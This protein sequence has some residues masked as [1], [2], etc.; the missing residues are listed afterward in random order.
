[1]Q[2][3]DMADKRIVL[4]D[5]EEIPGLVSIE[6]IPFEE[7][8]IDVPEI[9]NIRKIKNGVTTI[10]LLNMIYKIGRD[11]ITKSFFRDWKEKNEVKEV[12]IVKVDASGQ[13]FERTLYTGCECSKVTDPAYD[14][15]A[16]TYAQTSVT[17]V[18][19]DVINI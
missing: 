12:T 18:P 10:P 16:P 4:I 1:M 8:V 3:N 2:N 19:Y 15:A 7:G 13:E 6:E 5:N 9:A 14:G 11:T 17:V